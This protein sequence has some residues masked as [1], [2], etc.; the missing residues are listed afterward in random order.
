M[1]VHTL[2]NAYERARVRFCFSPVGFAN[3]N[4]KGEKDAKNFAMAF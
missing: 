1:H 2:E 3:E 4:K